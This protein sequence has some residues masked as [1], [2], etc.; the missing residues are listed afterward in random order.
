M[1]SSMFLRLEWTLK[2]KLFKCLDN[3]LNCILYVVL[4][5]SRKEFLMFFFK[6]VGYCR[7]SKISNF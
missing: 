7:T 3:V 4:M 6:K 5:F 2:L 1:T